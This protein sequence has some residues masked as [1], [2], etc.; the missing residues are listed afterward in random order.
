MR[1]FVDFRAAAQPCNYQVSDVQ[2][3]PVHQQYILRLAHLVQGTDSRLYHPAERASTTAGVS[4]G[5]KPTAAAALAAPFSAAA[6]AT[7]TIAS[8][9]ASSLAA[10]ALAAQHFP[11]ALQYTPGPY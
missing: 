1:P 8:P 10:T 7:T 5:F 2:L 4:A 6:L 3:P 11:P 9:A